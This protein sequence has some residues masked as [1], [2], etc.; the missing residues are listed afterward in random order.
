MGI[1]AFII[2]VQCESRRSAKIVLAQHGVNSFR[3]KHVKKLS[4][5]KNEHVVI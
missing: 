1:F 2:S 5:S 4:V 3:T